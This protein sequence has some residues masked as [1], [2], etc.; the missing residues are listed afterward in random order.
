MTTVLAGGQVAALFLVLL[1]CTGLVVAAP[2][3]GHHAVPAVV[4]AGLAA[5]L[6]V[7]MA[8]TATAAPGA[9]P[10]PI[11]A[12]L[13]LGIGLALGFMLSLGFQAVELTGRLVSLQMGLSLG[14]VFNPIQEEGGTAIDPFFA[15]L[16]GLLFLALGLHLA[17]VQVLAHSFQSFPIGGG[18]PADLLLAGARTTALALELGI[19]IALPMALVLLLTELAVAMVARAIPQI[20]VFILGMPL[21][22]VLGLAVLAAGMP[23]LLAG[24]S[25]IFRFVVGAAAAPTTGGMLP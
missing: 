14:A 24:A 5:T 7:A 23:V 3:F 10:L 15:V 16:A 22:I 21:K 17:V 19:R 11:A 18:W 8:G 9:L 20:N 4:K 13:E 12:P 6:T 25:E 1:R 2:I